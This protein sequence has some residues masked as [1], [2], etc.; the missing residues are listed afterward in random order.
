[1]QPTDTLMLPHRTIFLAKIQIRVESLPI[2]LLFS[3]SL[4]FH[5]RYHRGRP[6]P[7]SWRKTP[8]E[9]AGC[10][11]STGGLL[12]RTVWE[13]GG[14]GRKA[15]MYL[16]SFPA[17][18][19]PSV[20]KGTSGNPPIPFQFKVFQSLLTSRCTLHFDSNAILHDVTC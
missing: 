8:Q 17:D 6:G 2:N 10:H 3:F 12:S 14:E 1:M 18:F 20:G 19:S 9:I 5:I 7:F 16:V 4:L 15:L 13:M 11:W